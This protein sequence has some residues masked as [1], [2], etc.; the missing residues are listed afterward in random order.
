MKNQSDQPPSVE[1]DEAKIRLIEFHSYG[2]Y[3]IE[4]SSSNGGLLNT[5]G[6]V[7][8]VSVEAG[9]VIQVVNFDSEEVGK[10]IMMGNIDPQPI[11]HAII[12]FHLA[13]TP[14]LTDAQRLVLVAR[15]MLKNNCR[16]CGHRTVAPPWGE[17]DQ[18]PSWEICRC[19]G[20][21]FGYEDCTLT[22]VKKRRAQWVA[23][24][25]YWSDSDA[26]PLDWSFADQQTAIPLDF[27]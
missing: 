27:R 20:T 5:I 10:Q 9:K 26:M 12:A 1:V 22:S 7:S 13:Q 14:G 2:V 25:A 24:G 21:E 17:D 15:A 4:L 11:C 18:T 6:R 3:R 19:C 16:I 8:D 23:A